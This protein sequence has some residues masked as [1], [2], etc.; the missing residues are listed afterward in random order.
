[1]GWLYQPRGMDLE[2]EKVFACKSSDAIHLQRFCP[3]GYHKLLIIGD[4]LSPCSGF[5]MKLP[6]LQ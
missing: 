2:Y 3:L 5:S 1:M 4:Y 6:L